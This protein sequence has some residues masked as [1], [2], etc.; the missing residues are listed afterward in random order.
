MAVAGDQVAASAQAC[1]TWI[2]R[3]LVRLQLRVAHFL[4]VFYAGS[5]DF[6]SQLWRELVNARLQCFVANKQAIY[7]L[8]LDVCC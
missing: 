6:H 1:P 7:S 5:N 8:H 3:L 2:G 4:L